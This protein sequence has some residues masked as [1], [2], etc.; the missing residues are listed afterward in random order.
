LASRRWPATLGAWAPAVVGLA[1][2][3]AA[4]AGGMSATSAVRALLVVAVT[5]VL[6]GVLVWRAV[7]PRHGWWMEDLAMGFAIGSVL[8]I[9]SQIVAGLTRLPWLSAAVAAVVIAALLVVPATRNRITAVQTSPLPWWW[10]PAVAATMLV[11][12]QSLRS[13]FRDV[14]LSWPSGSRVPHVDAY[15]HLALSAE[16]ANR[17]PTTFPWVESE[18][19]AYHW[20]SHAWVAQ[21]SNVSG[22]ELDEVLFR[23]MP[24]LMPLVV[25]VAVAVAAVRL[26]GRP[27]T[28][29]V[30][31]VLAIAGGDFNA[32]GRLT[33]GYP[34]APLSPSLALAAPMLI[35]LIVVLALRWRHQLPAAAI[36][37]VPL[38]TLGAAGTKGSTVPL[39]VAGLLLAIAAMAVLD[40]SRIPMLV[41]DLV[42]V[43]SCLA[44]AFVTVF[45]G[46]GAGLHLDLPGAAAA[47]PV[48]IWLGGVT[49]G[50]S[51]A[52]AIVVTV[53][54]VF[55]RGF[56][57][58]AL[59]GRREDRRDPLTWLLI[60]ACIA[61]AIAVGVFAHPGS[62]QFYFAR[63]A[64]PVMAIGSALG[65][66]AITDMLGIASGRV[67][68]LGLI[69][70]PI[71][72]L[73]AYIL[74]GEFGERGIRHAAAMI[75]IAVGLLAIVALIAALAAS[76][77][78]KRMAASV[79]VI[80]LL[81]GGVTVV[82][83]TLVQTRKPQ[84]LEEVEATTDYAV[85]RGQIDA[86]RWI[87]ANSD[88]DDLV[89]TNRHCTSP[90]VPDNCDNRRWVT[91]AFS[92]RQ[93][94]VEGWTPAPKAQDIAP[95]GRDSITVNYWHPELLAL[96]DR[97]IATPTEAD[98]ERLRDLGVRW[99]VV[100]HTVPYAQT[101]QPYATLR[102][103]SEGVDVYEF[104]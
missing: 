86:A 40:R 76:A 13:Y 96:N 79:V 59:L 73:G 12:V 74:I 30:A 8:A 72:A 87:R 88:I 99:I 36:V 15:L 34:I 42:V 57:T 70:G 18:P 4:I 38:L 53:V 90:T 75:G 37:L 85:S 26:S 33:P 80:A 81:A 58:F 25:L 49:T 14:P 27:W 97:F 50:A 23:F 22:A 20:F 1:F 101:L 28:G 19:L 55:S 95:E 52:F 39:I 56:G 47:T 31:A 29:P 62:S 7:R 103:Q 54:G 94:L 89:M 71:V 48:G 24:V 21:V 17:G 84:P 91:A 46:S 45:G 68:R 82:V 61:G 51:Q 93:V 60:G 66:A 32:W 6:P 43:G 67:I 98:A 63:S 41:V 35:A 10:G 104:E 5:Q 65:L 77:Y 100:D 2:L 3:V 64:A 92:E 9:G 83:N 102:F 78:R 11:T 44:L 69:G 16:L